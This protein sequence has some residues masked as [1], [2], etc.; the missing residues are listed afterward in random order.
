MFHIYAVSDG[1]GKTAE[2]VVRAALTQY[3]N[4]KVKIIRY[5]GVRHPGQV[6]DIINEATQ[7]GGFI[8]HTMV[9]EDMRRVMFTEGRAVDVATIDLMGPMLARLSELMAVQPRAEP[10]LFQAFDQAYLLR[11]DAID[12]TVRHD[13]GRNID[14][15]DQAEIVLVGVSRTSKTPLSIYLAYRG[16]KVANVP[17]VLGMEP[18]PQLFELPRRRVVGLIVK[19]ERL[20]EL[21]KA[22]VEHMGTPPL[23]YAD[24][25]HIRQEVAYA[26][27]VFERR[28]DWPLVDV[29]TK[30]VEESAS[31]VVSLIGRANDHS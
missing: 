15:L 1:T 17:L 14:D 11:I 6:I 8:V 9:A 23:G 10:G 29:T 20:A 28:R 30:P 26:Y 22:R 12:Y 7:T 16:W 13:D 31:E 24:I 4:S 2:G 21:R 5:G 25:E 27:Q 18:S 19:P 3:D